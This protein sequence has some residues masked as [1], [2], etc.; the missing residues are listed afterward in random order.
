MRRAARAPPRS[1]PRHRS[2]P[3]RPVA[4]A[5]HGLGGITNL[6]VPG[7]LFLVG[8]GT[9]LVVSFIALGVLWPEP[10]LG[11]P[12]DGRPFPRPLQAV[13]LSRVLEIG[14]QVLGVALFVLV[15]TA[16]AFGS[17][18]ALLNLAPTFI[19]VVF[20]VGMTVPSCSSGTSGLASIRGGRSR[21]VS[22]WFR[23]SAY[24]PPPR[25]YPDAPRRL[26]GV[27]A[28]ARVR[29][30]EL[31]YRSPPPRGSL[32][33]A[34]VVYSAVTWTGMIVYGREAWRRNGDGFALFFDL[35]SR[36]RSFG[37][38]MR[39]GRREVILRRPSRRSRSST[40]DAALSRSSRSC[41]ARS[42][43]TASAARAGGRT[44]IYGIR[45]GHRPSPNAP[46]LS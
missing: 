17:E 10:R 21:T 20:W 33:N 3:R 7:W 1:R 39:D 40:G 12:G 15:F 2:S 19:Y 46:T 9:V 23:A 25:P 13:L 8:G 16:A 32:A 11:A 45:A 42:P 29:G 14:L 24:Q 37:S 30:L 31:V 36:S 6:P 34:I 4:R 28:A 35:L 26:A 27:C 44:C 41:S 5:A 38:R 43:S 18:R 22:R